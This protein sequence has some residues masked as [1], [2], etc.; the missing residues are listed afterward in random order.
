[1]FVFML[2]VNLTPEAKRLAAPGLVTDWCADW[3][4]ALEALSQADDGENSGNMLML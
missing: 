1:M 3:P 4:L 2:S